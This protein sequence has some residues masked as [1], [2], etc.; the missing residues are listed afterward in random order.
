MS[1]N[2]TFTRR[3]LAALPGYVAIRQAFVKTSDGL[4]AHGFAVDITPNVIRVLRYFVP[5][6]AAKNFMS[7]NWAFLLPGGETNRLGIPIQDLSGRFIDTV[8]AWMKENPEQA[9]ATI[10]DLLALGN[11]ILEPVAS[12]EKLGDSRDAGPPGIRRIQAMTCLLAGDIEG[13]RVNIVIASALNHYY[14]GIKGPDLPKLVQEGIAVAGQWGRCWASPASDADLDELTDLINFASQFEASAS[15]A[16]GALKS[17]A[18]EVRI[19]VGMA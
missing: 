11:Q 9:N 2:K 15:E 14:F 18:E 17:R 6:Y 16:I 13:C 4:V 10:T 3:A 12:L 7:L 1:F 5:L 19:S 8:Q